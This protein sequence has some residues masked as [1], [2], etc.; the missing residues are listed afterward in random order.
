MLL[1]IAGIASIQA[2]IRI[3]DFS[4]TAPT[5]QTLYYIINNDLSSVTVVAPSPVYVQ[6]DSVYV[7]WYGYAKPCGNLTIPSSVTNDGC[8]YTVTAIGSSAFMLCD[9][10]ST[11]TIPN[12]V[13]S[14]GGGAFANCSGLTT[15]PMGTSVISI[16]GGAFS[17]CTGLTSITIPPQITRVGDGA[18]ANCTG[19]TT[20]NYNADSCIYFGG[21][22]M[23]VSGEGWVNY[24]AFSGCPNIATVNV[25]QDVRYIPG[26]TFQGC[27][28][29]T[30]INFNADSCLYSCNGYHGTG[31]FVDCPNFTTLNIGSNV[32]FIPSYCFMFCNGLNAVTIPSNVTRIG[33]QAFYDCRGLTTVN[34]NADSCVYG[35]YAFTPADDT[36]STITSIRIGENVK[37]IPGNVFRNCDGI[38]SVTIP[39]SVSF[40]GQGAFAYCSSLDTI[41]YDADS[42]KTLRNSEL[43]FC[44]D[45]ISV[46]NIGNHV[47]YIGDGIFSCL[48]GITTLT[49][50]DSVRYIGNGAFSGCSGLTTLSLPNSLDT[51]NYGA[52]F[53]CDNLTETHYA[54]SIADWCD[55]WFGN[56]TANPIYYSHNLY[57]NNAPI[58]SLVVPD[59]VTSIGDYAFNSFST[60]TSLSLG[61]ALTTIA[62]A[63]FEG[64]SGLSSLTLPNSVTSVGE[65]AFRECTG[66]ESA[67]L[68][69]ALTEIGEGVFENCTNLTSIN[70]PNGVA[71]IR[72]NAFA[73]CSGMSALT[74]GTGLTEISFNAF[75][76]C[77]GLEE[78]T[79]YN[80]VAPTL[81]SV[82]LYGPFNDVSSTIP[83]NIPCGST[84]SYLSRWNY[85]SNFVEMAEASFT[86]ITADST[87]GTV[88]ILTQPTCTSPTAVIYASANA[89]Y[90]FDHWSDGNTDNPRTMTVSVDTVIVGY[91][92]SDGVGIEGISQSPYTIFAQ[93]MEVLV[94]GVGGQ[95][96]R[97]FDMMG[98]MVAI[99]NN[100]AETQ[101]FRMM[102]A[103]VYLV[104]VG[105]CAA[106][107]VVVR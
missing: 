41:N 96:V 5:G 19:L 78:I 99:E 9:S 90:H 56:E 101:H 72:D 43:V 38:T 50:T 36:T 83:V 7:T 61:N 40:I 4:A 49:I 62:E 80:S 23:W 81:A 10:I 52:F 55:I 65:Y 105:D 93:D 8:S 94:Q 66:L 77:T 97:I 22:I 95:C 91:F 29:L 89:G 59:V 85:F 48:G 88:T 30:T 104:Q 34:F 87:M 100:A 35:H 57:I 53:G 54:G 25:G 32:K 24:R 44:N 92:V 27:S 73:G 64:C 15:L 28:G 71:A 3:Y 46:L 12:T 70:I 68:S 21:G 107:R 37:L 26:Y 74:L 98:R 33:S 11:V 79:S 16:D 20:V 2:Q 60:M 102:S 82:G 14:I 67:A 76:G 6:Y 84:P 42:C 13:T 31:P 86:A 45:T 69:Y 103:G 58:T 1:L 39:R 18:F 17:G 106:Q 75:G 47:K 63:A 51:I